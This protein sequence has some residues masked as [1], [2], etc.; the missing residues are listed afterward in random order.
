MHF[1]AT[2]FFILHN[3]SVSFHFLIKRAFADPE[4]CDDC[5]QVTRDP[6]V[7]FSARV[8]KRTAYWPHAHPHDL[9]RIVREEIPHANITT[10]LRAANQ[11][12][13]QT[14]VFPVLGRPL[15]LP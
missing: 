3:Y 15:Q 13:L 5:G 11:R 14:P 12:E 2:R 7:L 1:T 10:A 8:V 6:Q 4:V 9:A